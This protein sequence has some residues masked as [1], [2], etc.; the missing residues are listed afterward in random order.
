M[1]STLCLGLAV[2]LTA[3]GCGSGTVPVS[4]TVTHADGVPMDG[5]RVVFESADTETGPKR[6]ADG[7]IGPDGRF[8]L[9]TKNPGDGVAPGP[10]LVAVIP[11]PTDPDDEPGGDD[12]PV[13]RVVDEKFLDPNKSGLTA[14]VGPDGGEFTFTV[15]GP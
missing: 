5:G 15:T 12:G 6:S 14:D 10:Y 1:R 13:S 7:F 11:P 8:V 3:A 2:A 9:R 4:G